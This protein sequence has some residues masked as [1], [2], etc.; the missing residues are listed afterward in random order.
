MD[1]NRTMEKNLRNNPKQ[2]FDSMVYNEEVYAVGLANKKR[3]KDE[4]G[5]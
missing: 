3:M 5:G 2:W 4:N 1:P